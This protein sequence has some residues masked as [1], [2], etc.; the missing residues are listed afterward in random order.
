MSRPERRNVTSVG[1]L[2]VRD[3]AVLLVRMSYG[4]SRGRLMLPGGLL[5]PGET[6]DVAIAREV[7]EETGVVADPVGIIGIRTRYDGPATDNYVLWLLEHRE[8]EPRA[9]GHENEEAGYFTLAQL[10]ARDDVTY[11]AHYMARQ[12][13]NHSVAPMR[14]ATD[15]EYLMPGS[16]EDSWRLFLARGAEGFGAQVE[17]FGKV[18]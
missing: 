2:V 11:L 16:T 18:E 12:V 3:D 7:L 5:D 13:L 10:D 15:Y 8:G 14:R 1:G 4:P 9:D 6:L 17:P